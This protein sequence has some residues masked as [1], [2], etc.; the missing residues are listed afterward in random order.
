M[1]SK[2]D[3]GIRK[4]KR[5]KKN[6][7]HHTVVGLQNG[8]DEDCRRHGIRRMSGEEAEGLA[9]FILY[10]INKGI[11]FGIAAWPQAPEFIFEEVRAIS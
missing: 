11:Q 6:Q 5:P 10:V 1:Q 3:A 2:I 4:Y 8:V 7:P 9:G